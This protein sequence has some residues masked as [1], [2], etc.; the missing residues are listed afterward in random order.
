MLGSPTSSLAQSKNSYTINSKVVDIKNNAVEVINAYIIDKND[1]SYIVGDVF[2]DGKVSLSWSNVNPVILRISSLG[3]VSTEKIIHFKGEENSLNFPISMGYNYSEV[4][5][6]K[7]RREAVETI[8]NNMVVHVSQTALS[9]AGTALDVL[10]NT[11]K[12]YIDRNGSISIIGKG[13]AVV[14]MDGRQIS[15]TQIL[16]SISSSDIKDIEVLETPGSQYD[17]AG[18]AVI[19]IVTKKKSVEG[20]QVNLLQRAA[21]GKFWRSFSQ[22]DAY[23][24]LNKTVLQGSY[25]HRPWSWGGRN[26][27]TR[28]NLLHDDF[29]SIDNKFSQRNTRRDHNVSMRIGH[30]ITATSFID[31]QWSGNV[32]RSNKTAENFRNAFSTTQPSF[33]I[34]G[35]ITGPSN[36]DN[37]TLAASYALTLD[38]LGSDLRFS[39]QQSTFGFNRNEKINQAFSVQESIE[40][41]NRQSV[42]LN[43]I[44]IQSAQVDGSKYMT[45]GITLNAGF[46][47]A[48]VSNQSKVDLIDVSDEAQPMNLDAFSNGFSYNEK[49]LAAYQQVSF[50]WSETDFAIGLREEWTRLKGGNAQGDDR[51]N[52]TASYFNVFPTVQIGRPINSYSNLGMS[53]QKRINRPLFQDLNPYV[54]YVDSLISLRGNP[55]LIPEYSHQLSTYYHLYGY[56]FQVDINFTK[57]KIN[58]VFRSLDDANPEA[59]SFVKENLNHTLL[60]SASL[61][62]SYSIGS[63]RT[64][65]MVGTFYDDHEIE[66]GSETLNNKKAGFYIQWNQSMELPLGLHLD[67]YLN[68]TSSRVD[69][70][71]TDNPISYL[72]ISLSKKVLSDRVKL[73]LWANDTF[74]NYKWTGDTAFNNMYA[75]YLSEGD[76]HYIRFSAQYNFGKLG[77]K[78]ITATKINRA[79]LN[80][81]N[82]N[83]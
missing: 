74:D 20:Y 6:I 36:Q 64:Y 4:V 73:I 15:S 62:K 79:E 81:I 82:Q 19:N 83:Q 56:Q 45:S 58:Q 65:I 50:K 57:N 27:Q 25:S 43:D 40:E 61:G 59:I 11:P 21:K 10:Q 52:Y 5:E 78:K 60:Y 2:Y 7:D 44:Q 26:T 28:R 32:V 54:I 39:F 46:K 72:N 38:S 63:H 75:T 48:Q 31:L 17:A 1:S 41:I 23:V 12:V 66:D 51:N 67:T 76:F 29:S 35:D 55:E 77:S 47:Y 33:S 70:V 49:I 68:Y 24:A 3:Y 14:Y 30:A 69:G 42:N 80:R 71:Y 22:V 9:E 8:G 37:H 53:Y 13:S 34:K 16:S 18:Q